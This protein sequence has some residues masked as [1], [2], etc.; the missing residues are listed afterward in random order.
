MK[1]TENPHKVILITGRKR[2]GKTQFSNALIK[3]A[4][5]KTALVY[6]SPRDTTFNYLPLIADA[7]KYIGQRGRTSEIF[8]EYE[9]FLLMAYKAK[10]SIILIDDFTGYEADRI[11]MNFRRLLSR[12][13]H[14]GNTIIIVTHSLSD[15]PKRLFNLLD[16]I[17][18]FKTNENMISNLNRLPEFEQLNNAVNKLKSKPEYKPEFIAL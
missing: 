10:N 17:I 16:M 4:T 12:N 15:T 11:S 5:N 8:V 2:S 1:L 18:L 6:Q 13:R 3:A 7:K 14:A 9:D